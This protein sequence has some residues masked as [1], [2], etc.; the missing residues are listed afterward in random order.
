MS[1]S[2]PM[3]GPSNV[4]KRKKIP[5]PPAFL[6]S[7]LK[8]RPKKTN[9]TENEKT[10]A[11]NIY[12][13]IEN[14]S[15]AYPKQMEFVY[16]TA[17]IMGTSEKTVRRILNEYKNKGQVTASNKS[18]PNHNII[19]NLDDFILSAIRRKVH[20]FYFDNDLPTI[21]KVAQAINEDEDLPSFSRST[22][23]KIMK[24]LNFKYMKRSRKSILLDRPDLM[25]WRKQYLLKIKSYRSQNRKIY[26]T[27]ET[28]LN[29][30]HTSNYVWND[31]NITSS[32]Q[33]FLNGLSTGLKNP[34]KGKRLIIAHIG[35]VDGFLKDAEWIFEAKKHD[36]DYHDEMDAHNFEKWFDNILNKVEPGSVIVLDNA[37]YHSR[38]AVKVPNM[39][40]RKA[41]IQAWLLENNISYDEN[42]IKAELLTKFRK[43]DYNKKVIDEMAAR[44]NIIVLRLPPYHCELNPIELIWAQVKAYVG[45]NNKSFKMAEVRELLKEGLN[46]ISAVSWRKNIEHVIKEEDKMMQLDGIMDAASDAPG[47]TIH[48][49]EES[50]DSSSMDSD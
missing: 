41:D 25:L 2:E 34:H 14:S 33:A 4:E 39:S 47:F 16:K 1:G 19:S 3:P 7:P 45:K 46:E 6:K 26:Y 40:W 12:K 32:R 23:Y 13:Y 35:S 38:L 36:G 30:G 37:P 49:S 15:E 21:D 50:C 28:W 9:L 42:E 27:D 5:N 17:Q 29:E 24:K 18:T 20:K 44:K 8:K 43:E 11:L 10:I 48:V 22:T 31:L